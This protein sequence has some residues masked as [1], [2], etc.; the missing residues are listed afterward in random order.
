MNSGGNIVNGSGYT[1]LS[2]ERCVLVKFGLNQFIG[3][4]VSKAFF[5]FTLSNSTSTT[6]SG[7]LTFRLIPENIYWS[8]TG[9]GG[10]IYEN[11][12]EYPVIDTEFFDIERSGQDD[13][14]ID[15]SNWI[16]AIAKEKIANNGIL[17]TST[18]IIRIKDLKM[19]VK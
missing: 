1:C 4:E 19:S 5:L 7:K 8:E 9:A 13:E 15:I 11:I 16:I 12:L 10:I 6:S 2:D 18:D 17:I 3:K 14:S